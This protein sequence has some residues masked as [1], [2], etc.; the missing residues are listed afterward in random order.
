MINDTMLRQAAAELAIA[1]NESLPDPKEC[2]HQ[3]S[4][5][6]EKKIKRLTRR[7][8]HPIIYRSLRRVA[9]ILLVVV[10]G[11][12]SVLAVSAEVRATVLGWVKE[13]YQS[14]Y[15]YFFEGETV[16]PET[17]AYYP[18]WLPEDCEFVTSYETAGGEVY[19][20]S[21]A[22]KSLIQF[23]YI[24][25]PDVE[26]MYMDGVEADKKTVMING[27]SGE[28]YISDNEEETNN[29]IWMNESQTVLFS[30]SGDYNEEILIKMAENIEKK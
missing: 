27:C 19:I 2:A 25:D 21:T 26:K 28:I 6:F 15:E 24:S 29:I 22:Q 1:M 9:S 16:N 11:F 20:Y 8:N 30:I 12:C 3:F 14:L 10:I 23:S 17:A 18:G 13:Q 7:T 4:P 5:K